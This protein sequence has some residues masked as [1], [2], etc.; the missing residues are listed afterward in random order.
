[1]SFDS[2]KQESVTEVKIKSKLNGGKW[3]KRVSGNKRGVVS[4]FHF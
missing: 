1:M 2:M 3:L 4:L